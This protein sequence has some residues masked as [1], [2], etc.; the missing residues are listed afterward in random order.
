ME[1]GRSENS[2]NSTVSWILSL[3]IHIHCLHFPC[4]FVDNIFFKLLGLKKES[5]NV[6][7]MDMYKFRNTMPSQACY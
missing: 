6:H 3:F 1:L 5:D 7:N 2:D 4:V